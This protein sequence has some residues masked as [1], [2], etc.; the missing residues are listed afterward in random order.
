[1]FFPFVTKHGQTDGQNY[2]PQDC[3]SIAASRAKN[4]PRNTTVVVESKIAR[5]H[6]PRYINVNVIRCAFNNMPQL[7]KLTDAHGR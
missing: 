6:G 1:M 4:R 7:L 5:F 3:A 2:D